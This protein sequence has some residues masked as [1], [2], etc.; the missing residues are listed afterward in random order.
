M[1][2]V[3]TFGQPLVLVA[4]RPEYSACWV[5]RTLGIWVASLEPICRMAF[6]SS[7]PAAM[8]P[9]GREY[10]KLRPTIST[11]LASSAAARVSPA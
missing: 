4:T 5:A 11:P 8:M 9:R 6:G 2:S 3:L 7:V 10:L 1:T